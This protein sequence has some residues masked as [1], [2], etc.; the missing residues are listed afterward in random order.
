MQVD[1]GRWVHL[2]E[3]REYQ[4]AEDD[5]SGAAKA[6]MAVNGVT[7]RYADLL[8]ALSALYDRRS[9][10][11]VTGQRCELSYQSAKFATHSMDARRGLLKACQDTPDKEGNAELIAMHKDKLAIVLALL[12]HSLCDF[13]LDG[14]NAVLPAKEALIK[15]DG[16]LKEVL[17]L[18]EEMNSRE[19]AEAEKGMGYLYYC[20]GS[21]LLQV[22]LCV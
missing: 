3:S 7:D 14:A 15:A 2:A 18:R 22:L 17:A 21:V 5:L 20:R 11:D 8:H 6:E 19:L 12:G 1:P 10:D 4:K 16:Y 9:Y 13:A